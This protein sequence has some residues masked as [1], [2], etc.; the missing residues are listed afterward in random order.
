MAAYD[1]Q[2]FS[3]SQYACKVWRCDCTCRRLPGHPACGRKVYCHALEMWLMTRCNILAA[4][5]LARAAK[6]YSTLQNTFTLIEALERSC[7]VNTRPIYQSRNS[8]CILPY[9]Q[10]VTQAAYCQVQAV[11]RFQFRMFCYI[12]SLQFATSPVLACNLSSI[13]ISIGSITA[14]I[15]SSMSAIISVFQATSLG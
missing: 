4:T 9:S 13:S 12:H 7:N 2:L 11:S 14:S 1:F 8:S 5:W 10:M 3:I 15:S 6:L